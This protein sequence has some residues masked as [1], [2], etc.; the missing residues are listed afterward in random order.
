MRA[1]VKDKRWEGH[2]NFTPYTFE[3]PEDVPA[4]LHHAARC[5][6]CSC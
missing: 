1:Q 3:A 6:S 2:A 5:V 4:E